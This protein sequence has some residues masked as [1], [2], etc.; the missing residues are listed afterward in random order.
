VAFMIRRTVMAP[1]VT[2][3]APAARDE[4]LAA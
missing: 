1:P 3:A 4:R 2:G